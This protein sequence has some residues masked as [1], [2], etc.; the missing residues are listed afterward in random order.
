MTEYSLAP[1]TWDHA[2]DL[3]PRLRQ[4]DLD[5]IHAATR[6]PPRLALRLSLNASRDS[7]VGLADDRPVILFGV[8]QTTALS[9]AGTP[10]MVGSDEIVAHARA[11]LRMSREYVRDVMSQYHYLE[12][13]VDAR[14]VEAV[15]WLGWLGFEV[16]PAEPFGAERL[17]FHRFTMRRADDV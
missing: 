6:L 3:L 4:A 12:N 11:F 17:P 10:W 9:P 5:E 14:N 15:R 7:Q 1:A 8:A 13:Y 2:E 16:H